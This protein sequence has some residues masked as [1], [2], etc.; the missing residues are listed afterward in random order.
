[1]IYNIN[2]VKFALGIEY[3]GSNYHGWQSQRS[4]ILSIQQLVEEAVSNVANQSIKLICAGRTDAKV[5]SVGQVA[6]FTTTAIRNNI[7]WI[8]GINSYLPHDISIQWIKN[9]DYKFDARHSAIA[10]CYR[11]VIYNSS[12]R[13][14]LLYNYVSHIYSFL[15]VELMYKASQLLVGEHDFSSFKSSTCRSFT[16]YR[17]IVYIN[18]FQFKRFIFIDIKANS[19]LQYM[20]RNIVGCLINIGQMKKKP[21]WI[22][23]VLKKRNRHYCSPT[24]I[25]NGLYLFSIDYPKC[26]KIPS[27]LF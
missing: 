13:S 17:K 15:N 26:F 25:S 1:M 18:V 12:F 24:A 5:H 16:P 21:D 7:S 20:V 22:K 8:L 2:F 23:Y 3:N 27:F 11:Y 10:R 19:F 14:S 4:G 9:V 6:H